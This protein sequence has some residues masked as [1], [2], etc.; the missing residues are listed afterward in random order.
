MGGR[1]GG[2]VNADVGEHVANRSL[3]QGKVV[4]G[5]GGGELFVADDDCLDQFGML[6]ESSLSQGR[7]PGFDAHTE[8]NIVANTQ[9]E[10]DKVG[11]A[12]GRRHALMQP[13]VS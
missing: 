5:E 8:S 12:G 9:T 13:H 7:A 1:V 3:G 6:V 11:V 2:K 10:L 4:S